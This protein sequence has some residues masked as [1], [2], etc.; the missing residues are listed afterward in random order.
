MIS[1]IFQRNHRVLEDGGDLSS[2][3]SEGHTDVA[4]RDESR[5]TPGLVDSS[6]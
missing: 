5:R 2:V 4:R 6:G 1:A 3:S